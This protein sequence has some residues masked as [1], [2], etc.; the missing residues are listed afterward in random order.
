MLLHGIDVAGIATV[1]PQR[2]VGIDEWSEQFGADV[3][4]RAVATTGISSVRVAAPGQLSSDLM[5][6]AAVS[7][8]GALGIRPDSVDAIVVVTTTPTSEPQP[9][10]CVLQDRLGLPTST[11]AIDITPGR[12]G[13]PYGLSLA[14]MLVSTGLAT[15]VLVLAGDTLVRH[16]EPDDSATRLIFG[17][18]PPRP[19]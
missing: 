17:E 9:T 3:V 8:L 1:I 5:F 7:I 13:Y 14:G 16:L 18:A 15:T 12:A 10:S 6:D 19:S 4:T 11:Y 2:A